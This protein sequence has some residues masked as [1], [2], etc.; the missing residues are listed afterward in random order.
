MSRDA[1]DDEHL[2]PYNYVRCRQ[3]EGTF[4]EDAGC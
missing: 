2:S 1:R 4:P 3:L